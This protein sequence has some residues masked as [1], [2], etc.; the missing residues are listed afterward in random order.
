MKS[1]HFRKDRAQVLGV[2]SWD[3]VRVVRTSSGTT[4]TQ[5]RPWVP[6]TGN[7]GLCGADEMGFHLR[8]NTLSA[9]D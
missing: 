5:S 2:E 8:E 1:R 4:G 6:Y 9:L 7:V 3:P